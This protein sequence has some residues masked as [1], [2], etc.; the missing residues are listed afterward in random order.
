MLITASGEFDGGFIML[1][2]IHNG[3]AVNRLQ[4][5]TGA[6]QCLIE[7]MV[8]SVPLLATGSSDCTV[9]VWS[10]ASGD[11]IHIF[12]G[13][14]KM[15]HRLQVDT[16]A[17]QGRFFSGSR[18][19]TV[20]LWDL[21]LGD[22]K[23]AFNM[24]TDEIIAIESLSGHLYIACADGIV[25]K[26]DPS[27]GEELVSFEHRQGRVCLLKALEIENIHFLFVGFED[28]C[29]ILYTA[30]GALVHVYSPVHAAPLHQ[31][32]WV[33]NM[34]LPLPKSGAICSMSAPMRLDPLAVV[35]STNPNAATTAALHGTD[36]LFVATSLRPICRFD[37][38][39]SGDICYQGELL[40]S[41]IAATCLAHDGTRLAV[42]HKNG[43]SEIFELATT[44]MKQETETEVETNPETEHAVHDAYFVSANGSTAYLILDMIFMTIDVFQL[45]E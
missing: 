28:G 40:S 15:V 13:H 42:G 33:H 39:E 45:T 37:A 9:R 19:G 6:I 27:N 16:S 24:S 1:W 32:Y 12:C 2:N 31:V 14:T 5:H 30:A 29:V 23:H 36:G 25:S 10:Q 4:G 35:A 22:S 43:S 7:L 18:D 3:V 26:V 21:D 20:R 8:D 41:S 34:L 38:G 11:C 44:K 17:N